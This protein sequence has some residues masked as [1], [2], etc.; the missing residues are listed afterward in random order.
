MTSNE[1]SSEEEIETIVI[2]DNGG[3]KLMKKLFSFIILAIIAIITI[4]MVYGFI[5]GANGN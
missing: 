4:L 5:S 1:F 3:N 2:G